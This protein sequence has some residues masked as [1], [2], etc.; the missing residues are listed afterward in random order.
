M[1]PE[2]RTAT[3]VETGEVIN[4]TILFDEDD[5]ISEIDGMSAQLDCCASCNL[6]L[7]KVTIGALLP[8]LTEM[9]DGTPIPK[10]AVG[11]WYGPGPNS[12]LILGTT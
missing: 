2:F 5:N 3:V 10:D 11:S 7:A 1:R 8:A 12:H 9:P 4:V 6:H